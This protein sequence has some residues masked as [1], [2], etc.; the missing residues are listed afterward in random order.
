MLQDL[1]AH[2]CKLTKDGTFYWIFSDNVTV[3]RKKKA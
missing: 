1:K 3:A 2:S